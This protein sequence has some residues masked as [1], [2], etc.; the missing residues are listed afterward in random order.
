MRG[1][2]TRAKGVRHLLAAYYL[3]QD[4]IYGHV[5]DRKTRRDFLEF[6][7]YIRTLYLRYVHRDHRRLLLPHLTTRVNGRVGAWA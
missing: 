2:Y 3:S 7:R 4:K 5:K 6:C 1:T